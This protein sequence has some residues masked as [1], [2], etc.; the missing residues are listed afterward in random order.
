MKISKEAVATVGNDVTEEELLKINTFTG[1]KLTA[2]DV[3]V[4]SVK[5]CDN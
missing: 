1:K 5:L 4:F 3:F 2:D